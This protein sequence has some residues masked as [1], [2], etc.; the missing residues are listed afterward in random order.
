MKR[1]LQTNALVFFLI[2]FSVVIYLCQI[3]IFHRP[4]ETMFYLLQDMAFLPISVLLVTLGMNA[5]L[6]R[7]E[8]QAKLNR[9]SVVINEFYAETGIELIQAFR[10]SIMNLN[11]ITD[12]LA[13]QV[14]WQD[15]DF[16]KLILYLN[17]Y[18]L[19]A[20]AQTD[21]LPVLHQILFKK[22]D[23]LLRLF[24][25]ANLVE[26]DRFTELL[27]S[28]YHVYD[29]LHSRESLTT[30]P[31][32]DL[33]HLNLDIQRAFQKLLIE[34]VESMRNLQKTYPYLYSLAIRKG[35]FGQRKIIV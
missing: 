3:T 20:D 1:N 34:W 31:A 35:L 18:P 12:K 22:K 26:H 28:L 24:E 5:V 9:V 13:L 21:D 29:E 8:H 27:W 10:G 7:R 6:I 2:V 11:E 15:Q 4:D 23:D 33:Q 19:K 30:L 25:N 32:S 16:N 17:Q 14:G